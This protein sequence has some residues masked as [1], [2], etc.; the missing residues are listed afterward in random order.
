MNHRLSLFA[1]LLTLAVALPAAAQFARPD[2]AI[3]Y[4]KAQFQVKQTH[5]GR[6]AAMANGRVPFDAK[7]AVDN[8][9]IVA[10]LG[11]TTTLGFV[12][13]SEGG[14]AKPEIWKET[15][16]FN[17]FAAKSDAEAAKLLVAAKTGNLDAIK[18]AVAAT[19]ASCKA[20]HDVFRD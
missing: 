8:A 2:D 9:E 19:G 12:P 20:C 10:V 15:A 3:K 14:S 17:D 7:L 16:R 11:R 6:L 1:G 5:L 13:G 4:R 18:T